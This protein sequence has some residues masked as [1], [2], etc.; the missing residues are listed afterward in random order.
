MK[1]G[2]GEV[3]NGA[4]AAPMPFDGGFGH[5]ENGEGGGRTRRHFFGDRCEASQ[6]AEGEG[7][8]LSP[9]SVPVVRHS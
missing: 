6:N 1:E 7:A 2:G 5:D 8:C 3:L 4:P 9:L